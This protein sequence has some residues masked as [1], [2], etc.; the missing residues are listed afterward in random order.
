[1]YELPRP[2]VKTRGLLNL[3][4]Y[5]TSELLE[6]EDKFVL[7]PTKEKDGMLLKYVV[8]IIKEARVIGIALLRDLANKI[9][10][11]EAQRGMLVGGSRYTPAAKKYAASSLVLS[12]YKI[13]KTQ[14]PRIAFDDPA[15]KVLG[16][17]RGQI[18]RIE[19][20]SLTS[21]SSYYYRLIT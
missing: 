7:Y 2:V 20:K 9:E 8:W 11:T 21:G 6:Y 4:A 10:E 15:V 14:L 3:R 12:H 18:L 1:M 17:L 16:A 19:R 13:N 5:K